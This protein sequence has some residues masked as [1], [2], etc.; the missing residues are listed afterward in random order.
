ME[1]K[2]YADVVG[3]ADL[4]DDVASIAQVVEVV[5]KHYVK[6]PLTN[7]CVSP[8]KGHP[9][10]TGRNF[11]RPCF[12]DYLKKKPEGLSWSMCHMVRWWL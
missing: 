4:D 11:C 6:L 2:D 3:D 9:T 12:R 10:Q 8:C 7:A 5:D 1:K